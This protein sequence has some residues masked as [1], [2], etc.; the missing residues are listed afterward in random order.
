MTPGGLSENSAKGRRPPADRR[1]DFGRAARRRTLSSRPSRF[2]AAKTAPSTTSSCR[3]PWSSRSRSRPTA[4][5]RPGSTS[6][7]RPMRRPNTARSPMSSSSPE[8]IADDRRSPTS[9]SRRT[10]TRTTA[11][12]TTPETRTIEQLVFTTP[13]AAKA[14]F[15]SHARPARPSKTSSRPRARRMAD[16]L[17]GTLRQGQGRRPGGRRRGLRLP[18]TKSAR[19]STARSARCCCASPRSSPKWCKP[20]AEV[21]AQIR[22]DLAL[23]EATRILLDVHDNY[24]DTPRRRRNRCAKRRPS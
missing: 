5:L 7:R 19:S 21:A 1:G 11:R 2:T 15:D 22:K 24:E 9:R 14:A 17:L 13:D 8:D 6:T 20:L 16:T 10:T 18:P 23:A 12:Y 3:T 4:A